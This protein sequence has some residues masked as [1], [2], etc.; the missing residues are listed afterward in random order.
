[1]KMFKIS[2]RSNIPNISKFQDHKSK[3]FFKI[4]NTSFNL[5]IFNRRKFT[6]SYWVTK[7]PHGK[8]SMS[9]LAKAKKPVSRSTKETVLH[10]QVKQ[11]YLQNGEN[12]ST[13]CLTTVI[14]NH[15]RLCP[16]LLPRTNR[17][18]P[19][20]QHGRR[21]SQPY[22]KWRPT[23]LL[24]STVVSASAFPWLLRRSI[25]QSHATQPVAHQCHCTFT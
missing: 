23:R 19:I 8:S 17:S 13:L 16:F 7:P 14:V 25:H 18:W 22:A 6:T 24:G 21:C 2:E 10:Q 20:H 15:H 11:I 5:R 4:L 9:C 12:T 3:N 1:M